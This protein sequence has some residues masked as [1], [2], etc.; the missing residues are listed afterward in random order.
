MNCLTVEDARD[1]DVVEDALGAGQAE[2]GAGDD[3][4]LRA[5][6]RD[7]LSVRVGRGRWLVTPLPDR[8]AAVEEVGEEVSELAVAVVRRDSVGVPSADRSRRFER[9]GA[10][11]G[12]CR[13]RP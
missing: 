11:I 6:R 1:V 7:R 5:D 10:S 9:S 4:R 12:R 8:A 2:R 3:D 13:S